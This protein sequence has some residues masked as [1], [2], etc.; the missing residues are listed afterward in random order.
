MFGKERVR[1]MGIGLDY[2]TG[3]GLRDSFVPNA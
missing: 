3:N 2:Q 1:R